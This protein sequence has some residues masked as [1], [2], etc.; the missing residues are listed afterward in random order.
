VEPPKAFVP[1]PPPLLHG[2]F[3]SVTSLFKAKTQSTLV[4]LPLGPS[5]LTDQPSLEASI[6]QGSDTREAKDLRAKLEKHFQKKVQ[7]ARPSKVPEVTTPAATIDN[8]LEYQRAIAICKNELMI[9]CRD[10]G[11]QVPIRQRQLP[12]H[13]YL[14]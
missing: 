8:I 1:P 5:V 10:F 13:G 7:Q 6:F 11:P 12:A 3:N 14:W 9:T 4:R 2:F